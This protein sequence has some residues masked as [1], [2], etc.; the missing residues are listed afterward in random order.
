MTNPYMTHIRSWPLLVLM[1]CSLIHVEGAHAA[2]HGDAPVKH[3]AV[4]HVHLAG[5]IPD[6][7]YKEYMSSL[8]RMDMVCRVLGKQPDPLPAGEKVLSEE[9][10]IYYALGGA[11]T[12]TRSKMLSLHPETCKLRRKETVVIEMRTASGTCRI[13]PGRKHA[14]GWCDIQPLLAGK[15][16]A[17]PRSPNTKPTGKTMT[18]AGL[19]C[20]VFRGALPPM[21]QGG[22]MK[23][24]IAALE[25]PE[26][27]PDKL[28]LE[29]CIAQAGSFT[30]MPDN[31]H[32]DLPGLL[33]RSAVW[34]DSQP[35]D[36]RPTYFEATRVAIDI[37]VGIDVLAPH[38]AGGY[39]IIDSGKQE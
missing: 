34:A 35:E 5:T 8:N 7:Q 23:E 31:G 27:F 24:A 2:P 19:K 36:N 20:A 6:K 9:E 3:I 30:G 4:H 14:A 16:K 25:H 15:T 11:T 1:A 33:L 26:S 21:P 10:D 32:S 18:I 17:E 22:S 12:Y 28:N 29:V 38:S 39:K 13:T 37:K